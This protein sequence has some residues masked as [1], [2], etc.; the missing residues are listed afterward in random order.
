MASSSGGGTPWHNDPGP[1]SS[2]SNQFNPLDTS[3]APTSRYIDGSFAG[4]TLPAYMDPLQKHGELHLL[5]MS[6][7]DDLPLPNVPFLIRKSVESQA[8]KIE[9]AF[10]EAG[11]KYYAL[12]VRS[13]TQMNRLLAMNKLADETPVVVTEHPTLNTTRCVVT[14]RDVIDMS[15]EE[16]K[17]ELGSQG[18]KEVR[19]I[20]RRNGDTRENTPSIIL[21]CRGTQAPE[22]VDFGYIR[23]RTRPYYPSPM[24]CFNC[25]AFGHTKTRCQQKETT[26]GKCSGTHPVAEDR[27]CALDSFCKVCGT[28]E[29]SLSSRKCPLYQK[30][31]TIQKIKVDQNVAYPAARRLFEANNGPRSFAR[32]LGDENSA[33]IAQLNKKM[34]ELEQ[35]VTR[36]DEEIAS[37]KAALLSRPQ[38]AAVGDNTE[39]T[40]LKAIIAK[41]SLQID[42]LTTQLNSFLRAVMPASSVTI[43]PLSEKSTPTT[44]ILESTKKAVAD[45]NQPA[46]D[47]F[48]G[49]FTDSDNSPDDP[50]LTPRPS[51]V[52]DTIASVKPTELFPKD[53][54]PK[55]GP[56]SQRTSVPL[57]ATPSKRSL[58]SVSPAEP[59]NSHQQK[60]TKQKSNR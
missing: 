12:K 54:T 44:I 6:G 17:M 60:K 56:K 33:A 5:R 24:Q 29:H 31:N 23:C 50:E 4:P 28:N 9:G 16:L 58:S 11:G 3:T 51:R 20:T 41:Q 18:V 7:K 37:L 55:P 13:L 27:S 30:E 36:K 38:P 8:G 52:S 2:N 48:K 35:T 45:P 1:S 32:V 57:P 21:S 53:S 19:R 47:P 43:T 15:E 46:L 25:W 49:V 59:G 22:F 14:C 26:C 34:E 10:K 39:I 42:A 40:D